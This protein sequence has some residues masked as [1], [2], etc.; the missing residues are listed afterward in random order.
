MSFTINPTHSFL[1]DTP[2]IIEEP[3]NNN[4]S[5]PNSSQTVNNPSAESKNDY[6]ILSKGVPTSGGLQVH[7]VSGALDDFY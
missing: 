2:L 7:Q 4:E 6:N 5:V 1:V 3:P